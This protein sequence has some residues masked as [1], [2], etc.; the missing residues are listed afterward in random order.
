MNNDIGFWSTPN[1][2]HAIRHELGHAVRY[3]IT[4]NQ[5]SEIERIRLSICDKIGL[6]EWSMGNSIE[7]KRAAGRYL[8]HY[9]L[10]DTDEFIAE[11]VA[12]FLNGKPRKTA[13]DVVRL[14]RGKR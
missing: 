5:Y 8:S 12:E 10:A 11:S 13:S 14:L 6:E 2:M 4:D 1:E 3:T 9:G 7:L